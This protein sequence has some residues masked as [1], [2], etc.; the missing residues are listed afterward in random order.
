MFV[1][2]VRA[3]T[4]KFASVLALGVLLVT[5]LVIV[6]PSPQ[7]GFPVSGEET[8]V[9]DNVSQPADMARFLKQFGLRCEEK[10]LF[11]KEVT[12]PESFEGVFAEYNELQKRQGLDLSAYAGKRLRRAILRV[13]PE[14]GREGEYYLATLYIYRGCVVGGDVSSPDP[15]G[16][17]WR[18]DMKD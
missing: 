8:I 14:N 11:D 3:S 6:L 10:L 13:W 18:F 4:L 15:Q 9:Y 7:T 16:G 2:S 5:V 12:L 17:T 1:C